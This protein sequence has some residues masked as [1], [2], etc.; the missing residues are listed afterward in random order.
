VSSICSVADIEQAA[1]PLKQESSEALPALSD[2]NETRHRIGPAGDFPIVA[3]A[4][5]SP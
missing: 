2:R 1:G 5:L 3:E 4:A